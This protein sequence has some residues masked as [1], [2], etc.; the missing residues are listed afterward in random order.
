[1][2]EAYN[3]FS[4]DPPENDSVEPPTIYSVNPNSLLFLFGEIPFITGLH[5]QARAQLEDDE[6]VT[7]DGVKQLLMSA[8]SSYL[9]DL[10]KRARRITPLHCVSV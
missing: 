2:L 5:E 7:I 8:R 3:E 9:Q 4:G 10:G 1:M 6:N